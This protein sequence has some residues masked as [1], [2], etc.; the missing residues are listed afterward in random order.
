[1]PVCDLVLSANLAM[2]RRW[3]ISWDMAWHGKE[4]SQSPF[5][6]PIKTS[7]RK[8]SCRPRY[9]RVS[10]AGRPCVMLDMSLVHS[11]HGYFSFARGPEALIVSPPLEQDISPFVYA[12]PSPFSS[13]RFHLNAAK[14]LE[15]HEAPFSTR[16]SILCPPL[17]LP[18][19]RWCYHKL[20]VSNRH[21]EWVAEC[22]RAWQQLEFHWHAAKIP[23]VSPIY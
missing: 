2:P 3:C 6:W 19:S 13:L 9:M 11:S 1:M 12:V 15:V 7:R 8:K 18:G 20:A 23:P 17:R 21:S 14:S 4:S 5:W 16:R 10:G 22:F